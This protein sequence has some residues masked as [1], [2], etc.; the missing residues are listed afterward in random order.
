MAGRSPTLRVLCCSFAPN[1][2]LKHHAHRSHAHNALFLP[3]AALHYTL[4]TSAP[5]V[6][7]IC[8]GAPRSVPPQKI[9]EYEKEI[10][11]LKLRI[12]HMEEQ[13]QQAIPGDAGKT[14]RRNIDLTVQLDQAQKEIDEKTKLCSRAQQSIEAIAASHERKLDAVNLELTRKDRELSAANRQ[15]ANLQ[16]TVR[17]MEGYV[18]TGQRWD[19]PWEM[20]SLSRFS[21]TM[22]ENEGDAAHAPRFA[23]LWRRRWALAPRTCSRVLA[24]C[25]QQSTRSVVHPSVDFAPCIRLC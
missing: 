14:V 16:K 22:L 18:T 6:T 3:A 24:P 2:I 10:F 8:T 17:D 9:S 23:S 5:H 4:L 1:H 12:Y 7:Y 15:I 11:N 19:G 25:L 13:I 20:G 21:Q